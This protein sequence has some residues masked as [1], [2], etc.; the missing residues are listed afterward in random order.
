MKRIATALCL[1][2]VCV[3][4]CGTQKA[5]NDVDLNQ[6]SGVVLA[7]GMAGFTGDIDLTVRGV[8][9]AFAKHSFG[10]ESPGT[11]FAARGHVNPAA[12]TPELMTAY[13]EAF[14]LLGVEDPE[15]PEL[16]DVP[17]DPK[18]PGNTEKATETGAEEDGAH[19]KAIDETAPTEEIVAV[20]MGPPALHTVEEGNGLV[21]KR[22]TFWNGALVKSELVE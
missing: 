18:A 20:A 16:A 14:R 9:A 8:A 21:V 19:A 13:L 2:V 11:Q 1:F 22:K 3:A 6:A 15:P 10:I 5:I 7:L 17:E 12:V 4:G